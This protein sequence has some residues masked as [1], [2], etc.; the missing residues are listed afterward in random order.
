[1]RPLDID[2][3]T[4]VYETNYYRL[5][6]SFTE[7]AT[8]IAKALQEFYAGAKRLDIQRI[9]GEQLPMEQCYINLAIVE[10]PPSAQAHTSERSSPFSLSTRLKVETLELETIG[11]CPEQVIAYVE[12]LQL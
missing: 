12:R 4:I 1:M 7:Q 8:L 5:G 6:S 10:R 3:Y 11:F 2:T 9:S